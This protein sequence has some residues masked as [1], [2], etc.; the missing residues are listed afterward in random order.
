MVPYTIILG[1]YN[2]CLKGDP[3]INSSNPDIFTVQDAPTTIH[4]Y[5]SIGVDQ[6]ESCT[7]YTEH[8]YD[9]FSFNDNVEEYAK[10]C[11]RVEAVKYI[12]TDEKKY[13]DD[14]KPDFKQYYC[15]VSDH[16]PVKLEINLRG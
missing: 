3:K 1:D 13:D 14:E 10:I 9:H 8:D 4:K 5:P 11:N 2:L 15:T 6:K 16:V 7:R 12:E